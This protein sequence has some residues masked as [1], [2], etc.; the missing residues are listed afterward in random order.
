VNKIGFMQGRLCEPVHGKIQAFPSKEWQSE[1]P[2]AASIGLHLMEWTLDHEGLA[3]N[4]LMLEAGRRT[5]R[6]LCACNEILIPSLTGDCFMQQPF[7]KSYGSK[8]IALQSDFMKVTES[9]SNLGIGLVVVPLV[10]NGSIET[11]EQEETLLDFLLE[12]QAIF[13]RQNVKVIFESDFS[14]GALAKFI[15]KLPRHQFGINYDIGNS[16][17]CG[18]CAAE[19][20]DAYGERVLNV[21]VKDRLK[22]G[23]TVPLKNGNADF[24]KVFDAIK[25]ID[26]RGNFILQTARADSG[27]HREVLVQYKNFIAELLEDHEISAET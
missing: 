11:S 9:C 5:I 3:K 7:W 16:A 24:D 14:P 4:P 23:P 17:A 15:S 25:K 20:L 13:E 26:Y 12:N 1:L 10:D 18:F 2:V 19:E 22:D 21:H 6:K 8:R 27:K